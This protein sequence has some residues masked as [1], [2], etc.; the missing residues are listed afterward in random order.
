MEKADPMALVCALPED[1]RTQRRL[2]IQALL[3]IRT[4]VILHSDGWNWSGGSQRKPHAACSTS[5]S[6][7]APAARVSLTS[8]GL[9]HRRPVSLCGCGHPR[10]RF[11]HS[12]RSTV[13]SWYRPCS[14]QQSPASVWVVARHPNR[15]LR[16][17]P[18]LPR[19]SSAR[20]ADWPTAADWST[21]YF[22]A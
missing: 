2:E 14:V 15:H 5:F 20:S 17:Q 21:T 6:S 13:E 19:R 22:A 9:R 7:S 10:S 18:A 3:H 1:D 8:S 12:R 11:R 16:P 4:A